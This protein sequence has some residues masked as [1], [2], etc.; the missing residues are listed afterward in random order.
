[1]S[2]SSVSVIANA[3]RLRAGWSGQLAYGAAGTR[4]IRVISEGTPKRFG[5]PQPIS[6]Q[7]LNVA[8]CS[9]QTQ[10]LPEMP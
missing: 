1:M 2:L 5:G 6:A 9:G 4:R 7:L 8:T 10:T 3:L